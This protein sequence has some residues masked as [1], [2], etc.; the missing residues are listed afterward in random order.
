MKAA[1]LTIVI[2]LI[3]LIALPSG[4]A[5]ATESGGGAYPNGAEDFMAGAL[6]PPGT[7]VLNY[8]NYYA[9]DDFKNDLIP[10]FKLR[11]VADVV[12]VVHVTKKQVLGASWAVQTL[13][14]V[15]YLDVHMNGAQDNRWGLGDIIIDPFVL[16]WHF[17]N[18]HVTTG[19]DIYMPT[20]EFDK[21]HLAN[22][23]RNYW[24]FEPVL[25]LTYLS[26]SGIEV[27]GKFMYDFN[28][29]NTDTDYE[30][31]QE[32]HFDYALGYHL[33]KQ[34]VLGVAGYYYRQTTDD[35]IDGQKVLDGF[36]GRTFAV[37]PAASY[38]F[39]NMNL[40]LK[41]QKEFDADDRP[42]GDKYWLK[43]TYAF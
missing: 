31:G 21:T 23:G 1:R 16:G 4:F 20:G 15:V 12:R 8:L 5:R 2:A 3:A 7:Y 22:P 30:S 9:A 37:G 11:A 24:T 40:S 42:E 13:I 14:P 19:I 33:G 39:R 36:K 17:K 27:S 38:S 35:E 28:T 43:F 32:F 29:K 26:D 41:Y 10:D 6:P 34:W 18:F 25:G